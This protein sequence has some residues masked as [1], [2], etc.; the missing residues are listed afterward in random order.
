MAPRLPESAQRLRGVV[1]L[2]RGFDKAIEERM[3]R[4][5]LTQELWVELAGHKEWMIRQLDHLSE[6][7]F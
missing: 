4:V 2:K 1:V 3:R 6:P 5:R 7:T